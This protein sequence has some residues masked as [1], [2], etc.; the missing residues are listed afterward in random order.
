MLGAKWDERILKEYGD[1]AFVI[2]GTVRFWV[3]ERQGIKEFKLIGG[4]YEE[5][6]IEEGNSLVFTFVRGDG[7]RHDYHQH[8]NAGQQL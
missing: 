8:S 1:F 2:R 4:K 6:V 7:N 3:W 5:S